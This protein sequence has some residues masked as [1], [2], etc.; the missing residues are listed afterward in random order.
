MATTFYISAT[1]AKL[2]SELRRVLSEVEVAPDHNDGVN[3]EIDGFLNVDGTPATVV[4]SNDDM[5]G[6][7]EVADVVIVDV[8]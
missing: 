8:T 5:E 3:V 7:D 4:F 1:K 2:M 6:R